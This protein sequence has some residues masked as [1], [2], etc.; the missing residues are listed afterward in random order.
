MSVISC[1]RH[2]VGGCFSTTSQLSLCRMGECRATGGQ[3]ADSARRGHGHFGRCGVCRRHLRSGVDLPDGIVRPVVGRRQRRG[4]VFA[5]GL[6][7]GRHDH[8]LRPARDREGAVRR[9]GGRQ[10]HPGN[11]RVRQE[12][13]RCVAAAGVDSVRSCATL[14]PRLARRRGDA[15]VPG[16]C[17][18]GDVC[19]QP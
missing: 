12:Q 3:G 6:S 9:S 13:R 14:V 16:K 18:L 5:R 19:H 17:L 1:A 8:R 11:R 7:V 10:S 2:G 15:G 4:D